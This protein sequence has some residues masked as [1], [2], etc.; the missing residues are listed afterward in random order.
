MTS[1]EGRGMH[2]LFRK[3]PI[4][5]KLGGDHRKSRKKA[6]AGEFEGSENYWIERYEAGK[7]SGAGSY[8]KLAEF[9]AEILNQFVDEENITTVIEFGCGDGNQL[10]L[11]KYPTYT[12]FDV[13]PKSVE[14]CQ[15]LF[16]ADSS[17]S[18][19]LVEQ[20]QDEKAELTLSLDVVYHLVEDAVFEDYMHRL[21][22]AAEKNVIIYSSDTD[23]NPGQAPHVRH[24]NFTRWVA[25]HYPQWEMIR[26][27]PN[28]YPFKGE[29][30][31]GSFAD[32]FIFRKL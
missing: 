28:R 9:K 19:K 23:D 31:S 14:L 6:S 1:R 25:R 7:N 16:A 3:I 18:F 13:S 29:T 5:G 11:A 17:K 4:I 24:R 26:H 22:C 30:K 15:Q 8:S 27:I 10:G 32:F 20:Y 12:G 2:K 21:F